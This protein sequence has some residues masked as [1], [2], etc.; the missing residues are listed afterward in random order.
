MRI[1]LDKK[2]EINLNIILDYIAQDKHTAAKNSG[3]LFL[4]KSIV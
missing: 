4:N 2:F 3:Q 1:E